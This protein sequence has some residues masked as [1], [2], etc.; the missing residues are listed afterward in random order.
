MSS[1]ARKEKWLKRGFVA[2]GFKG[3]L[4]TLTL[5]CG[6]VDW[7]GI[8]SPKVSACPQA[9]LYCSAR[10]CYKLQPLEVQAGGRQGAFRPVK[11]RTDVTF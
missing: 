1:V 7:C 11:Q 6:V 3:L 5:T 4:K 9:A 2:Q 10:C 8:A